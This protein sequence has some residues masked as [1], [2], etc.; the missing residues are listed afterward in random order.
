MNSLRQESRDIMSAVY[1]GA[2]KRIRPKNM[3]MLTIVAGLVPAIY[4]KGV[5]AEV[6]SRIALPMLGGVIS[7]FL[8]A[9]FLIPA[10]YSLFLLR[11]R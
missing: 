10:L 6:I 8:T 7:S 11:K 5:G 1:E 3:T 9:L 2:I 4:L